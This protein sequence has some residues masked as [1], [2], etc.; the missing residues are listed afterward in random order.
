MPS[1]SVEKRKGKVIGW[2]VTWDTDDRRV[3]LR[4]GQVSKRTA[5]RVLLLVERL[6]EAKR[7]GVPLDGETVRWLDGL[8]AKITARLVRAGLIV[9]GT[10]AR[11]GQFL[12][13]LLAER[14]GGYKPA[15]LIAWGQVARSLVEFFGA[16]CPLH[17]ITPAS[18]EAFRQY[19][20]K[21][22]YRQT[23]VHKRLQHARMFFAV[24]QQRG[25]VNQNPFEHV[26]QRPGDA[27]ERRAYVPVAD[28]LRL[29]DYC[30]N[31]TWRVLLALGRFGGLRIPSEAFSLK[32]VDVDWEHNRLLVPSP[33]TEHL[34][35]R[36]Y[37]VMPL[38]PLLRQYLDAAWAKAPEGA[39]Y[40][41]PEQY[42]RRAQGPGG[43]RNANL[44][45]TLEKIVRRAGLTPWPRLWHSLRAS[46]ESDLAASF[47]LAAVAKWL[48]NTPA[49]ALQHYVDPTDSL[50]QQAANWFP[51][52][53]GG[54]NATS[55]G[56]TAARKAAQQVT[57]PSGILRKSPNSPSP[58]FTSA[59]QLAPPCEP[60][61]PQEAEGTGFEP[62]T[63]FGAPHFQCGC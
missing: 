7:L 14:R 51:P 8:D 42:R 27:A 63:P 3:T 17:S 45:T 10:Q 29:M 35:G 34:P 47:P 41:I 11:L 23:T 37:R 5:Q 4:L 6:L 48:G 57:A 15:S 62:A 26:R 9:G 55:S 20:V 30:P 21:A 43:W 2:R 12:D 56:P 46:C 39:V 33:K 31:D 36:G 49:I 54:D 59:Q 61:H 24:A 32:W 52:T 19:M 50:F 28:V 38:F 53:G 16:D 44:R 1:L 13:R 18:A 22:G 40:V 60:I 25:L 58:Q